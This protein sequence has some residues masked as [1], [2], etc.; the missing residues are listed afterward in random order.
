M[1]APSE[2]QLEREQQ[3]VQRMLA[4]ERL[5]ID[6]FEKGRTTFLSHVGAVK[7]L[8]VGPWI[9]HKELVMSLALANLS[10]NQRSSLAKTLLVEWGRTF[11]VGRLE[12]QALPSGLP[13]GG[14]SLALQARG[15]EGPA[16]LYTWGL[17]PGAQASRCDWLLLRAQ[18]EWALDE[19]GRAMSARGMETLT[20]I[21]GR[22]VVFLPSATAAKQVATL[23]GKRVPIH[24]HPRYAPQLEPEQLDVGADLWLWPTDQYKSP[25]LRDQVLSTA[26]LIA[27]TD[28]ERTLLQRWSNDRPK[29]EMVDAACPGRFDRA[30]LLNF[31]RECG[32]PKVL[33]RGESEWAKPGAAWLES[34]GVQVARQSKAAQLGLF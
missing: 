29:L 26:S 6:L 32:E 10:P 31:W 28:A 18:P 22:V 23:M 3:A 9:A 14:S 20:G 7:S 24:A 12:L 21:G 5:G 34:Q 2:S 33:L 4:R 11:G 17:G 15:G 13:L 1:S 16:L 8:V 25:R 30:Q 27:V 19:P